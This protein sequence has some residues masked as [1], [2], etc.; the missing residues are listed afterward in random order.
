VWKIIYTI[1]GGEMNTLISIEEIIE[2]PY[3]IAALIHMQSGLDVMFRPLA[4]QDNQILGRYFLGL[5]EDTKKRY[6]P[7]PFTQE[8]A[9]Q[10]CTSI[11]MA[12]TIRMIG[13]IRDNGQ[14]QVIAY[15]ILLLDVPADEL[16][17]YTAVGITLDPYTGCLIAPSVADEYQNHHLGTPLMQHIVQTAR[18]LGRKQL[19]LMGGVFVTNERA[20]HFYEKNGF[21]SVGSWANNEGVVSYDMYQD[22]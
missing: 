15:F 2:D 3:R 22:L 14:E 7:H 1:V 9:D 19:I 8:M 6:G 18:R 16:N 21:H 5:S 11:D 4:A 17:R 13:T 20:V 10:L 12:N